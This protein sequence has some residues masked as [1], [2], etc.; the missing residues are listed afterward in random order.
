MTA[1][2][3]VIYFLH[4]ASHGRM[5]KTQC[6]I[7]QCTDKKNAGIIL[8]EYVESLNSLAILDIHRRQGHANKSNTVLF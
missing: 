6:T 3:H 5:V 2:R 4:G 1:I 8:L 7:L